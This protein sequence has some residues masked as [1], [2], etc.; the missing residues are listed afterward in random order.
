MGKY[1]GF[2]RTI[3]YN[4]YILLTIFFHILRDFFFGY[5]LNNSFQNLRISITKTQEYLLVHQFIHKLYCYLAIFIISIIIYRYESKI[6]K[7][8]GNYI[9]TTQNIDNTQYQKIDNT[10]YQKI[11]NTQYQKIDNTQYQKIFLFD[12]FFIFLLIL[13]N[14][15]EFIYLRFL[16]DLDFWMLELLMMYYFISRIYNIQ[17]YKH[18][19]FAF[20]FNI[21]PCILKI[22]TIYLSSINNDNNELPILYIKYKWLIP[23]GIIIFLILIAIESYAIS[24]IKWMMDSRYINPSK[25]L[26][27][28]GLIG[29]MFYLI[30]SI[31]STIFNCHEKIGK[32]ICDVQDNEKYY[33]E[34]FILYF[35]KFKGNIKEILI[36]VFINFFGV[37]FY[38][39][40]KYFSLLIIKYLSPIHIIF[41]TP[42]IYFV[43]KI[44]L[45]TKTL[46]IEGTI[47]TKNAIQNI[48][49]K[50]ILDA[51]GDILSILG[52]TIYLEIIELK[53]CGYNYNIRKSIVERAQTEI[54]YNG[55]NKSFIFLEN[56]DIEEL[57]KEELSETS[58]NSE[59]IIEFK[60][61]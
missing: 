59:K 3:R 30:V 34:N 51:V 46:I 42:I 55:I 50:F 36:E 45:V 16:K 25:I 20:A 39:L 40:N 27:F 23:L 44:A 54:E 43:E 38:F 31:V 19:L 33:L 35:T 1:I 15:L 6:N 61:V 41:L 37:I 48:L 28:F 5:N 18:Q 11:D 10:Q 49:T 14:F 58:K 8:K 53:F 52:F 22:I 12:L 60:K 29:T 7:K 13:K 47:F 17:L 57:S 4:K 21:F 24:K 26:I 32:Y 2:E 9:T 56:G